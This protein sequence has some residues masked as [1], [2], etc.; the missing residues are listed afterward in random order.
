MRFCFKK[1][2]S[3][4]LA[5]GLCLSILSP[6]TAVEDME[7]PAF[8]QELPAKSY[9]LM[10]ASTGQILAEQNADEQIPPASITKI[11]TMLLV[12]ERINSGEIS[13]DDM[14]TT[15]EHASSMGGTQI[16]LEVGE[17]MSVN[18]LL[19]ATAIN[20]ANDAAVALAEHV[21]GTEEA[22]AQLMNQKAAELGMTGTSFKNA[23]GLDAE[24][25]LSTARNIAIMGKEL[26]KYPQITEYTSVYMDSLRGGE[27][28][29]VNT[30]KLVRF[31]EGCNGIKTGTTDGAGSCLCASA[32]RNEMTLIAVS[33]GSETSKERFASCRALLDYGFANYALYKPDVSEESLQAIPVEQ[34]QKS[35]VAITTD[36]DGAAVLI[37]KNAENKIELEID[38]NSSV[39]APVVVGQEV[40]TITYKIGEQTVAEQKIVTAE[41]IDKIDFRFVFFGLFRNLVGLN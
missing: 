27:T 19:K 14:V 39:M 33:M 6:A 15:S 2:V 34:G 29:L 1:Y 41:E 40:G 13:M 18:D 26:L 23:T 32:E 10:E 7:V 36:S 38:I 11:M 12:M 31:Y 37:P 8:S 4:V 21:A 35:V 28:E 16:W 9:V 25:H 20:S 3:M 5:I 22:F 24:G 30:N 17:E